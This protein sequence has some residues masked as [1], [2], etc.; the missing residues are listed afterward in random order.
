MNV[1]TTVPFKHKAEI[2]RARQLICEAE[3]KRR[4][5]GDILEELFQREGM[6]K[7]RGMA[8]SDSAIE[9]LWDSV[10]RIIWKTGHVYVPITRQ[11]AESESAP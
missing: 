4:E 9:P 3:E 6:R 11:R 1:R 2:D 5:A 7:A 10:Q 8:I